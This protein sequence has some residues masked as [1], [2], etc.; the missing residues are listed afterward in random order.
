[1]QVGNFNE[2][3]PLA[4]RYAATA[5]T[6]NQWSRLHGHDFEGLQIPFGALIH[7]K[8]GV[9]K[10]KLG[11]KTSVGLFLGWRIEAGIQWKRT[12]LVCDVNNVKS[13]L[14]GK[15]SLQVLTSMVVVQTGVDKFPLREAVKAKLESLEDLPVLRLE[16]DVRALEEEVIRED[17]HHEYSGGRNRLDPVDEE[18]FPDDPGDR[19]E[20]P[21]K[22]ESITFSRLM[23]FGFSPGCSACENG[24]GE[25]TY[26]CRDRF[27]RLIRGGKF[28]LPKGVAKGVDSWKVEGNKLIRFHHIKRKKLF[29]P[30][31]PDDLPVPVKRLGTRVTEVKY[32]DSGSDETIVDEHWKGNSKTLK[33]FWTGRT[34]FQLLPEADEVPSGAFEATGGE[35]Q[36][37]PRPTQGGK[38]GKRL[39]Q[40]M[41]PAYGTL[42]EF[43]CSP[44]SNL[45]KVSELVG[46]KHIRL[47]KSN[48]NVAELKV[49]SQLLE[50]LDTDA[51]NGVDLWGSLP[52]NPWSSWQRLN[53]RRLG[54]EFRRR[55]MAKRSESRK[56]LKFFFQLSE[57]ILRR[58]GRI[59]FEWPTGCSGWKIPE[60]QNFFNANGFRLAHFNGCMVG[61]DSFKPWTVASTDDSLIRCLRA[62]TCSRDHKHVQLQG[63]KT[64]KSAFYPIP[65]CEGILSS[66]F[67]DIYH[68]FVP[69]MSCVPITGDP[70]HV[71]KEIEPEQIPLSIH[72][73][74]DKKVWKQDPAAIREAQKEAQGL[75]DAGT[76]DYENVVPRYELERKS[77]QSGA[78]VAIGKLMTIMSWKNAESEA[79]KRLKARIVFL[80]NNVRDEFGLASEFQEIKIIPTTIAGLNINLAFGLRRG[81]KTSQSD[82]VKAYIQSD[83]RTEHDTYIELPEEL[84]PHHLRWMHRPCTKLHKSLYGHPESGGHWGL[85]FKSIMTQMNGVESPLFPSNF[86]I[87]KRGLLVTLYVDDI[88]ISGPCENHQIFWS[89][90]S[91]HLHFETPQDVSKVLGRTH[92][93]KDGEVQLDMQ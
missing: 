32:F 26:S 41:L 12:Y 13:W 79:D 14:E 33:E 54:P 8:P 28:T 55:L 61:S 31:L 18:V 49:Q 91:K 38:K 29:N 81:N 86:V 75:I 39:V 23:H 78:K 47:T 72:E 7:Y 88:V 51:M 27:D 89:E 19:S 58:G 92:L 76:W 90:L 68:K 44:E 24:E 3:W 73:L 46:V 63:S 15:S 66:L 10:S 37:L 77:R 5:S 67:P 9:P 62:K 52:C 21:S 25:H 85:K 57:I 1:M 53:L 35:Q 11:A 34:I 22:H 70:V 74:I 42:I 4:I 50:V 30:L 69:S 82:V 60:L 93:I 84:I 87:E 71:P 83:L 48:G 2:L 40:R 64:P 56:L 59:H 43:C 80:G 65:M 36:A 16:D 17:S 45:G 6:I 20:T